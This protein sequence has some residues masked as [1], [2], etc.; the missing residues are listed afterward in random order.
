MGIL[1]GM[2]NDE[3]KEYAQQKQQSLQTLKD[4]SILFGEPVKP[5]IFAQQ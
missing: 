2:K 3:V 5:E 1:F 4:E